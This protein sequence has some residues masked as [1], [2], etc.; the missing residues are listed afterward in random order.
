MHANINSMPM[1]IVIEKTVQ[2]NSSMFKMIWKK[3]CQV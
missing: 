3:V 1:F 2:Q